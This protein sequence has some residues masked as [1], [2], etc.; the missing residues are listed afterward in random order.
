MSG[1][2]LNTTP[3]FK[4]DVRSGLFFNRCF[5]LLS[6][7]PVAFLRILTGTPD[8]QLSEFSTRN[9]E[10]V[11]QH[12]IINDFVDYNK[13]YFLGG[14]SDFNNFE[15]LVKNIDNIHLYQEGSYKSPA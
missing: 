9:P 5:T 12:T 8:V 15:G 1:N 7:Q 11:N 3:Y 6:V 4:S 13:F 10:A 14:S 2:P